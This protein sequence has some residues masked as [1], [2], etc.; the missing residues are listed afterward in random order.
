MDHLTT[1]ARRLGAFASLAALS[2]CGGTVTATD[3]SG[4]A[5]SGADATIDAPADAPTTTACGDGAGS[6]CPIDQYCSFPYGGCGLPGAPGRCEPVAPVCATLGFI[7][8]CGCDGL[9]YG[10]QCDAARAG[11]DIASLA[12]CLDLGASPC[13]PFVDALAAQV[14]G[15]SCTTVVRFDAARALLGYRVLCGALAPTPLDE[16]AARATAYADTGF[17]T[18]CGSAPLGGTTAPAPTFD[19]LVLVE[20]DRSNADCVCCDGGWVAAVSQASGQAVFGAGLAFVSGPSSSRITF[21]VTWSAPAELAAGCDGSL[22][23]APLDARGWDLRLGTSEAVLDASDLASLREVVA[24]TAL[25]SA[26]ARAG[27]QLV[28]ALALAYPGAQPGTTEWVVF[29]NSRTT[30]LGGP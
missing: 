7:D 4:D 1:A 23:I 17:G 22:S 28:N 29:V 15:T 16:A 14:T 19:E 6:R 13:T 21:P 9:R 25:P 24:R 8:V 27:H 10:S 26:L 5:G 30:A 2:G 18:Q 12:S 3:P 20:P 11:T